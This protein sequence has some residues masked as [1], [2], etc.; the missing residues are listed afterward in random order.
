[1]ASSTEPTVLGDILKNEASFDGSRRTLLVDESQALSIGSVC[2]KGASGRMKAMG[3]GVNEVQLIGITGT[4]SAGTFTLGIPQV[5]GGIVWTDPIAYNANTAGI[6]TGVDTTPNGSGIVVGG[7]AITAMTFTF[8]GATHSGQGWSLIQV[9]TQGLT[10][11]EDIS[12][13]RTTAGG[14]QVGATDEVQTCT[15]VGTPDSGTFTLSVPHWNGTTVT[16]AAIAYNANAATI[17]TAIDTA[18]ALVTPAPAA[19][20]ISVSGTDLGTDDIVLTYD[21]EEYEGRNWPLATVDAALLLDGAVVCTATFAETTKGGPATGGAAE[22]I[23]LQAITTEA[24]ELTTEAVFLVR[25]ATVDRNQLNFHS[26]NE[27]D[28]VAQLEALGISCLE[29]VATSV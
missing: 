15:C 14:R 11:E 12:I 19:G 25:N 29:E 10:G 4:L 24:S 20:S 27:I 5:D 9:N 18:F 13:T 16:T 1:M 17:E 7:T 8:S 28:C 23:C 6:Q 3:A 2:T 22:G 26:G 21:G